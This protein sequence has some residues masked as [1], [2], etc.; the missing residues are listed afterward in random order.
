MMKVLN[1]AVGKDSK[2]L[3]PCGIRDLGKGEFNSPNKHTL[4]P[5]LFLVRLK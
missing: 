3:A 5:Y 1:L 4:A 2:S